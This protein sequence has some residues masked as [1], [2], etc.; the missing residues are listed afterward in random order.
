MDS[1]EPYLVLLPL[2]IV[3]S[4]FLLLLLIFL[5]CILLLRRRRSITLR[6]ADG[7]IDMSREEFIDGDGGFDGMESR[8]LES[9]QEPVRR[10]YLRAKGELKVLHSVVF[11]VKTCCG[12]VPAPIPSKLAA[13][14]HNPFPVLIDTRERC[15]CLVVR[16]RLRNRKL[17]SR[18]RPHGN[19][20]PP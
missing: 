10:E 6:D 19:Y 18:P 15:F 12:R 17:P 4:T 14:R 7:P 1:D 11:T 20:F 16:T 9:V 5:L 3:L 8:W 13:N 2:L